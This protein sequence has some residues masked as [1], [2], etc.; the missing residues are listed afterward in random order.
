MD[1]KKGI[2]N[3]IKEHFQ[4]I[5]DDKVFEEEWDSVVTKSENLIQLVYTIQPLINMNDNDMNF[6]NICKLKINM[7]RFVSLGGDVSYF[8]CGSGARGNCVLL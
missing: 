2:K 8:T 4:D 1:S 6:S 7:E 3:Q 5:Y